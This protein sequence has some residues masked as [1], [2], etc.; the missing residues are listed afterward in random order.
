MAHFFLGQ[1]LRQKFY[2]QQKRTRYSSLLLSQKS[3]LGNRQ[4]SRKSRQLCGNF[5]KEAIGSCTTEHIGG[6]GHLKSQGTLFCNTH[7]KTTSFWT[8]S[9]EVELLQS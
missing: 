3:T 5:L 2:E 8:A 9:L 1:S 6:I 4:P 7:R